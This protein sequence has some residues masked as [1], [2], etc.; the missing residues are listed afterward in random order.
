MSLP[1]YQGNFHLILNIMTVLTMIT[2]CARKY[3]IIHITYIALLM[4]RST[5][6]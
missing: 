3:P 1:L 5:L 2:V 6:E 4:H